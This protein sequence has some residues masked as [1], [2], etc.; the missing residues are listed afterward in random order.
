MNH[1]A[2]TDDL[3]SD[4]YV[5]GFQHTNVAKR[6]ISGTMTTAFTLGLSSGGEIRIQNLL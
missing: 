1:N 3:G 2:L 6:A 5:W 4:N